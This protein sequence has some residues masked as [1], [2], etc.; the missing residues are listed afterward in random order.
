VIEAW[1]VLPIIIIMETYV[2]VPRDWIY[3]I[4]ND[5]FKDIQPANVV[6]ITAGAS[7]ATAYIYNQLSHKV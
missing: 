5:K 4:L 3:N 6:L 1:T 7:L 2:K